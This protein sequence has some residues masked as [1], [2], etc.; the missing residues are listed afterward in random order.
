MHG[1][2][3]RDLQILF[4]HRWGAILPDDDAGRS[5]AELVLHHMASGTVDPRGRMRFWLSTWAPWLEHDE[6]GR[7]IERAIAKP[8]RYRADT[9]AAKLNLK[10][11][12][13][14]RWGITTIGATDKRK[15][16]RAAERKER[17]RQ[18]QTARRRARGAQQRADY[19]ASTKSKGSKPWEAGGVSRRTWYRQEQR[20][21]QSVYS[22]PSSYAGHAACHAVAATPATEPSA[23][24]KKEDRQWEA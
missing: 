10:A 20:L 21:A 23:K 17:K 24:S 11:A 15:E 12:D 13:R 16:K 3:V 22:T 5:D 9:L 7:M 18:A 1:L 8:R 14:Q 6:A 4:R 2:R 19:I